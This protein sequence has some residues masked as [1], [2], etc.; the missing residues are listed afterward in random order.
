MFLNSD[1]TRK[2]N[3]DTDDKKDDSE[4]ADFDNPTV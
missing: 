3:F 2:G 4:A 1:G